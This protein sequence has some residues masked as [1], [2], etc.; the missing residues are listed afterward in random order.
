[1]TLV[2]T[3]IMALTTAIGVAELME[4]LVKMQIILVLLLIV[5]MATM[6]AAIAGCVMVCKIIVIILEKMEA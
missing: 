6:L 2:G 4:A 3:I 5:G 1:M